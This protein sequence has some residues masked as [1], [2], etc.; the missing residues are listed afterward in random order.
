MPEEKIV[1]E[2]DPEIA[3]ISKVNAALTGLEPKAQERVLS[4]VA[5]KL[6]ISFQMPATSP[7]TS[8]GRG[9]RVEHDRA[10][11]A[12]ERSG[13]ERKD[14]K[15]P[16]IEELE[17]ISP[18]GRKWITRNGLQV[19]QLT[20][21]F[22]I[23]GDEIDLVAKKVPGNSKAK[24]QRS[25]F[26]LKGLASYLGSGA[27]RLTFQE[28][29]ETCLHY[30]AYDSANFATNLKHFA[31]EVAGTSETGYSLTA[32]GISGATDMVKEML[33]TKKD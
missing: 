15:E 33:S 8:E 9:E 7:G 25:V 17:G 23:G 16:E 13:A 32:R 11:V 29:K 12:E 24:R 31:S 18:A 30:D 1:S 21:I 3:A 22:S 10:G 2:S 19:N 6:G 4:Y 20:P 14:K 28:V 27:A 5:A 26:L